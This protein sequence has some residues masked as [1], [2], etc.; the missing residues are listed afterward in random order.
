M[1]LISNRVE[2]DSNTMFASFI[3]SKLYIIKGNFVIVYLL[4]I[5]LITN[6]RLLQSQKV[7]NNIVRLILNSDENE[8]VFNS[9][10]F[11]ITLHFVLFKFMFPFYCWAVQICNI[12]SYVI[13]SAYCW[14]FHSV[15][16]WF[17]WHNIRHGM[18]KRSQRLNQSLYV[19]NSKSLINTKYGVLLISG[20]YSS[21]KCWKL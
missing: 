17:C 1:V 11:L 18:R 6:L 4:T 12:G 21:W 19:Y 7:S 8:F 20:K 2:G 16:M 13:R 14:L 10:Y 9:R 3:F 5:F 15:P